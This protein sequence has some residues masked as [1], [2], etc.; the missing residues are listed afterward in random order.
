LVTGATGYI[1]GRLV[2]RLLDQGVDVRAATRDPSRLSLAPWR[3]RIE[4]AEADAEL[5]NGLRTALDG[6]DAA[7]YLIHAMG[8][9]RGDFA[10]RDR[11]AASNFHEFIAAAEA[12]TE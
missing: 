10:E 2:P 3:D 7:F 12:S 1:G 5:G 9:L 4:V 8:G 6:C 11:R